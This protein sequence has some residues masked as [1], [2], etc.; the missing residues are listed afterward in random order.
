MNGLGTGKYLLEQ[1][2]PYRPG[3]HP[4]EESRF[5]GYILVLRAHSAR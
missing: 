1:A 2:C 5:V 4:V 3:T